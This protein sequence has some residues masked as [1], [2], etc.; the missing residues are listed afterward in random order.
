MFLQRQ[1]RLSASCVTCLISKEGKI[2]SDPGTLKKSQ[3]QRYFLF[4]YIFFGPWI[5]VYVSGG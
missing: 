3:T 4:F 1:H 2:H 5:F